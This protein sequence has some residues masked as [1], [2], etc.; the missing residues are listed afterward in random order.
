MLL[1]ICSLKSFEETS[2]KHLRTVFVQTRNLR[3]YVKSSYF[4]ENIKVPSVAYNKLFIARF[5]GIYLAWILLIYS[6]IL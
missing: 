4:K 6:L 3:G 1:C 2:K 5:S